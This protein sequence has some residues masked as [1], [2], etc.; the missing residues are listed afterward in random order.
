MNPELNARLSKLSD[1]LRAGRVDRAALFWLRVFADEVRQEFDRVVLLGMG[2]SSLAPEVLWR[3]FGWQDGYPALHMLDSTVPGAVQNVDGGGD[4]SGTLFIVASKSGTTLE[5]MSFFRHFWK[6]TGGDGRQFVAITDP[7]TSLER[8]GNEKSFRRVFRNPPDIGGR[9]SALSLFGLVPA[10]L[11]GI[12]VVTLLERAQAMAHRCSPDGSVEDN[13]GAVLGAMMAEAALAGRDKLSF[14]LSP[15][16]SSFGLWV[17]QLVAESTGKNDKGIIPVVCEPPDAQLRCSADRLFIGVSLDDDRSEAFD[18]KL[19]AI[20]TDGSP[21]TRIELADPYDL[22]AEFF[23]WEFATAV[24]GAVLGVNPFDQPNVAESK[25]NTKRVLAGG[26]SPTE[27]AGPRRSR[28]GS[29]LEGVQQ[30]DYVSIQAFMPPSEEN[31][32]RLAALCAALRDRVDAA[33]TLGYGP[34]YLHSTGQLHKGGPK[35]GHFF[36][37]VVP[38]ENDLGIPEADYS[39]GRLMAAQA[40]GDY[41]ALRTRRRPIIRVA[42]PTDLL[43]LM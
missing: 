18:R 1:D 29:L 8:L 31:D 34:R 27:H 24:A 33:V 20:E 40:Q 15:G 42:D 43:E 7:G 25:E 16:V 39:F 11:L 28:V 22:G 4:L 41:E 26:G 21:L 6:R 19:Q 30:G 9:Y 23:R 3:T 10:A 14:V 37:V 17:E 5:T 38:V 13:P 32:D 2:G 12:E 35:T 36:Q